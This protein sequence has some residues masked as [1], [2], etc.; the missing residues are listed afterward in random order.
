MGPQMVRAIE[1]SEPLSKT[2]GGQADIGESTCDTS[3]GPRCISSKGSVAIMKPP[4]SNMICRTSPHRAMSHKEVG[5][6]V[7]G[8]RQ[9]IGCQHIVSAGR[10]GDGLRGCGIVVI[11][12]VVSHISLPKG[13]YIYIDRYD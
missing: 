7:L 12:S 5:L 6:E 8:S 9:S 2:A 1:I 4:V 13:T 3:L 11:L 10:T